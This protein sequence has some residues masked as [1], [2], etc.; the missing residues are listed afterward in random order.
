MNS[1]SLVFSKKKLADLQIDFEKSPLNLLDV[2][3]VLSKIKADIR[4]QRDLTPIAS[5]HRCAL[6]HENIR[7]NNKN[8]IKIDY[9]FELHRFLCVNI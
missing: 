9:F 6:A 5:Q 4:C 1:W 3:F 8:I 2:F 7:K